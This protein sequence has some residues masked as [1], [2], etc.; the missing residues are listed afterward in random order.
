MARR[1]E[2][3]APPG[4]R[5]G[6]ADALSVGRRQRDVDRAADDLL[7]AAVARRRCRRPTSCATFATALARDTV[8][9]LGDDRSADRRDRRALAARADG[10]PRPADP[11]HGGLRAAARPRTPPAVV[12]NEAL[13]L[14]RTF[15]TE[16]SVKFI[17]GMLDAHPEEDGTIRRAMTDAMS[18]RTNR[19]SSVAP[20]SPSSRALGVEIY[21]RTFERQHTDLRAGRRATASRRTT[22][23]RPSG[24]RRSPAAAF[25]RSA[26]FGKA[27]FLVLSDGRA[28][29]PG[30]HP[31]G[32]RC[33]SSIS[34]SSSCSTSATGSAS[35]GGCS[36]PRPT[37]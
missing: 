17:N 18:R 22:S 35:K 36:A 4:P 3:P 19:F 34:R 25:S 1:A 23:S 13:E 31:S 9:R 37:S 11:A 14:A 2:G 30:L 5:G 16:E 7:R 27:N 6:A 32:L 8:A 29:D 33:R 15:S 26:S 10:D 21:P 28:Q 24:P 20:T 12:I